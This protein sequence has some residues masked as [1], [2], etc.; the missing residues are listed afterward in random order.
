VDVPGSRVQLVHKGPARE[1]QRP[2]QA[3]RSM[4][5]SRLHAAVR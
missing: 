1:F 3:S 4:R 5:A 2:S